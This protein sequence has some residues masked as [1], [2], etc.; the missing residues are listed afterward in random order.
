MFKAAKRKEEEEVTVVVKE[1][2]TQYLQIAHKIQ[3]HIFLVHLDS[4]MASCNSSVTVSDISG[5]HQE[6]EVFSLLGVVW[7]CWYFVIKYQ[8]SLCNIPEEQRLQVMAVS[9][10]STLN[11]KLTQQQMDMFNVL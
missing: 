11:K 5:F 10:L 7:L 3:S 8:P 4:T 2:N 1:E 6:V 9:E